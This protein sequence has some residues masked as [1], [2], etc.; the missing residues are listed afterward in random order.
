M[1]DNGN[2]ERQKAIE[3]AINSH[4]GILIQRVI[5][6]LIGAVA[7]PI[8]GFLAFEIYTTVKSSARGVDR[9]EWRADDIEKKVNRM[10]NLLFGPRQP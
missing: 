10:E 4:F 2:G 3:R 7:L 8:G 9:L 1:T 6:F 5:I